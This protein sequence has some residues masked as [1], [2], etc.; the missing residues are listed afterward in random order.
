MLCP[1]RSNAC[2]SRIKIKSKMKYI[3]SIVALCCFYL[4][5]QAVSP[6]AP[7]LKKSDANIMGHV[8][9]KATKEHLP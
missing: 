9:N 2:V 3:L 6:E 7:E 1:M 8:L 5:A 4:S